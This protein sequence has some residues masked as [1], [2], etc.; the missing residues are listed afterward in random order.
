[1]T[2]DLTKKLN[3]KVGQKRSPNINSTMSQHKCGQNFG[4]QLSD[5]SPL[6]VKEPWNYSGGRLVD[7]KLR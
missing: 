3:F 4:E 5:N 7:E 1:M 2:Q 6:S